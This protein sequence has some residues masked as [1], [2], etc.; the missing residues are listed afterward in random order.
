MEFIEKSIKP[1]YMKY[2]VFSKFI[3]AVLVFDIVYYAGKEIG[4]LAYYIIH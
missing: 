3:L 4:K 2:P 1:L